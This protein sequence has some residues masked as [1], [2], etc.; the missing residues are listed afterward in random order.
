[1][2]DV[3]PGL[4]SGPARSP[5]THRRRAH[6]RYATL[7]S[8]A[9]VSVVALMVGWSVDQTPL[10]PALLAAVVLSGRIPRPG[11]VDVLA[12]LLGVWVVASLGWTLDTSATRSTVYLYGTCLLLLVAV[13]HI[14]TTTRDLLAVGVAFIA[15]CLIRAV[16]LIR[17]P[18]T[19]GDLDRTGAFDLSVRYGIEGVNINL[20]AYTMVAG[21]LLAVLLG[22]VGGLPRAVRLALYACVPLLGYAVL[23]SGT[24]GALAALLLGAVYL[25]CSRAAPRACWLV[26][27]VVV[28]A[29]LLLVPLGL[30][31]ATMLR[32][33]GLVADRATGDL[34]GRMLVWPE[35]VAVWGQSPLAGIGAGAFM[36]VSSWG[37]GAH[38]LVLTL[39]AD[40]GLVGVLCYAAVLAA[41]IWPVGRASRLGARLAGL[42]LVMFLPIW[43][44]GHWEAALAAWLPL[45]LFS[46]VPALTADPSSRPHGT[47]GRHH[48]RDHRS[49]PDGVLPRSGGRR[50]AVVPGGTSDPTPQVGV[51]AQHAL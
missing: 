33:D 13:R 18:S 15:G 1:M 40:L 48:R 37:I 8:V 12:L 31:E 27:A 51:L 36:A 50:P 38:S 41:A 9:I 39:G 11:L 7:V 43:L 45:A 10:G 46:L 26:A 49:G 25:V 16:E 29:V 20:T 22:S 42:F 21:I 47:G 6:R 2:G 4:L 35:A 24:R 3:P 5:G 28:P 19:G 14:V 44:T 30:G 23:L 32:L 34:A 17:A